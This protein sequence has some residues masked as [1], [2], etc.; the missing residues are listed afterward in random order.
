MN[1][2]LPSHQTAHYSNP[3]YHVQASHKLLWFTLPDANEN[4]LFYVGV[5]GAIGLTTMIVSIVSSAVQITGALRASRLIFK[6]LLEGVV[7][8][9]MRWHDVTPQ[10][11][12]RMSDVVH[13]VDWLMEGGIGRMLNRFGK[14]IETIDS[15]LASSLSAV[16]SSL[17]SFAAAIITV[18]Y[19]VL[20]FFEI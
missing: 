18:A 16:N 3:Y 9:T 13:F 17:A 1:G 10:G 11:E 20:S 4:P 14:D 6:Q 15:N 19:V 5:Y 12:C 8:A 7:R 2:F